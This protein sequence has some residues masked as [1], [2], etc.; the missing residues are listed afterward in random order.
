VLLLYT[1]IILRI[2]KL[3][4]L[5]YFNSIIVIVFLN[6]FVKNRQ[7][8]KRPACLSI[9]YT[10]N[11]N[12]T[13]DLKL[14]SMHGNCSVAKMYYIFSSQFSTLYTYAINF[15]SKPHS[16]QCFTRICSDF[17]CFSHVLN[18]SYRPIG[19]RPKLNVISNTRISNFRTPLPVS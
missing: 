9:A 19:L 15:Q 11:F 13:F 8:V 6:D 4:Y 17:N 10:F 14:N 5:I 1:Q 16:A 12:K 2:S 3:K 18:R 7:A